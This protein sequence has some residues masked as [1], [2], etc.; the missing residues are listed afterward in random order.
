MKTYQPRFTHQNLLH[1]N[2]SGDW[3]WISSVRG[4]MRLCNSTSDGLLLVSCCLLFVS[5]LFVMTQCV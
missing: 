5:I 1:V 2:I 3:T 4:D